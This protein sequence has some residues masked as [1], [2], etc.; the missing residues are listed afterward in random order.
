MSSAICIGQDGSHGSHDSHDTGDDYYI[1][2]NVGEDM[3]DDNYE[4]YIMNMDGSDK[5]NLTNAPGVEWSYTAWDDNIY[6]ISDIDT[7]HRY[8]F[9]WEMKPD[10]TGKRRINDFRLAD[11]WHGVRD[12]GKEFI[13]RPVESKDYRGFYLIDSKGEILSEVLAD[14]NRKTDVVF[15][16]DGKKIAYRQYTDEGTD[17]LYTANADGS[18]PKRLTFFPADDPMKKEFSYHAGPPRWHPGGEFISYQSIKGGKVQT[19]RCIS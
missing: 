5:R 1:V 17:E 11:S 19:V 10:G 7:A 6:Y 9:L 13:V 2:Y 3:V 15:S 18:D 16:P 4:V 14:T 8:Y 12:G